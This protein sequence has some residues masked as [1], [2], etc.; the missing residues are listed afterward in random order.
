[1]FTPPA[2]AVHLGD[3]RDARLRLRSDRAVAIGA[4][5]AGNDRAHARS[6]SAHSATE[7]NG[8]QRYAVAARLRDARYRRAA[9]TRAAPRTARVLPHLVRVCPRATASSP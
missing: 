5:R 1:E 9:H 6:V 3:G 7:Q 8:A 4:P 2:V